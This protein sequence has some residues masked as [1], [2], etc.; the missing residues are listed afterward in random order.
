[1]KWECYIHDKASKFCRSRLSLIIPG[2]C[3]EIRGKVIMK[4]VRKTF[5]SEFWTIVLK[6]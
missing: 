4:G 3:E 2:F 1:M 6:K 5:I